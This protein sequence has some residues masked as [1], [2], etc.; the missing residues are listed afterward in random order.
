MASSSEA[1]TPLARGRWKRV[2]IG[3]DGLVNLAIVATCAVVIWAILT[4]ATSTGQ[5]GRAA[6]SP[7]AT[8]G[9]RGESLP[10]VQFDRA[11]RTL[12]LYARSTCKYCT[13]S[14]PLYRRLVEA[15]ASGRFQFVSVGAEPET[16]Q[17]AYFA[18]HGVSLDR[19]V[20]MSSAEAR[21][22]PTLVVVDRKGVVR[23]VWLGQQ[24]PDVEQ[25]I[26]RVASSY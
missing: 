6:P 11:E 1:T 5:T 18:T 26:L 17:R 9:E 12:V 23:R 10:G 21:G 22:T 20:V 8:V 2:G 7:G 4:H 25:E 15:K 24:S 14:M 19:Y 16:T 3:T 13:A